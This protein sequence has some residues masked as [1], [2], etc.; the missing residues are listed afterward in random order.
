[1]LNTEVLKLKSEVSRILLETVGSPQDSSEPTSVS[2]EVLR[3]KGE[4]RKVNCEVRG[5]MVTSDFE[6]L[7][8]CRLAFEMGQV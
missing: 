3:V 6:I 8:T 5:S 7:W 4:D 2:N 1:M